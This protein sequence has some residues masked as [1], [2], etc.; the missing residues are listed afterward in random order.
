MSR[1]WS[2]R[3]RSRSP[4]LSYRP[5]SRHVGHGRNMDSARYPERGYVHPPSHPR[6]AGFDVHRH[7]RR[8][9]SPPRHR[10]GPALHPHDRAHSPGD[11]H[12]WEQPHPPMPPPPPLGQKLHTSPP[13]RTHLRTK[14]LS[15]L[16]EM[17]SI[18]RVK[19]QSVTGF[20]VFVDIAGYKVRGLVPITEIADAIFF[21]EAD[22]NDMIAKALDYLVPPGSDAW[23]KVNSFKSKADGTKV[24][25][26]SM[27]VVSQEDG[28]DLDPQG[29]NSLAP[30][31]ADMLGEGA[32]Q[33]PPRRSEAP[34]KAGAPEIG[35]ILK[36]TVHS[37]KH[38]G[39]FMA[40]DGWINHGLV[41]CKQ[42]SDHLDIPREAEESQQIA[43]IKEVVAIGETFWCKVTDVKP[44]PDPNKPR[45]ACSI[46]VV[47]Q[48]DGKDLD[49]NNL[50]ATA[51]AFGGAGTRGPVGQAAGVVA[52]SGQVD[53]GH[54][55]AGDKQFGGTDAQYDLVPD[56]P[57]VLPGPPARPAASQG[58]GD[59]PAKDAE[60]A[61]KKQKKEKKEKKEKD[62][63]KDADKKKHKKE[64]KEPKNKHKAK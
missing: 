51:R 60:K 57:E 52:P 42:I 53:W 32:G 27:K 35:A 44:G 38:F 63:D 45:I 12:R 16:P 33:G 9:L 59:G 3:K 48:S 21:S 13:V 37:I 54:L 24:Y 1:Q 17:N 20:G 46:K 15:D 10:R 22:T 2:G 11:R 18:H 49:P 23:V 25:A 64:K 5:D 26:C 8:S 6:D 62:S 4:D 61:H 34:K 7:H 29:T 58:A 19:V 40:L 43:I 56:E 50:A 31:T 41:H 39:L 36:G 14:D 30:P 28:T 47:A 55:A